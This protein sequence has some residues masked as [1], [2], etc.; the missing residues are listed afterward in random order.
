MPDPTQHAAHE[1]DTRLVH[2][3]ESFSDVVIGFSLA[4][5]A[6]TLAIPEHTHDLFQNPAWLLIYLWTFAVVAAIWFNHQRLFSVYFAPTR[7][8]IFLNFLL[9]SLVGL[10]VFFVQVFG[11]V[12]GA[13]DKGVAFYVYWIV[14]GTE[15]GILGALFALGT[16]S[17]WAVL[18][19]KQRQD[20]V[21]HAIRG[22]LLCAGTYFG[23]L[24]AGTLGEFR[25]GDSYLI[26]VPIL[27]AVG[28]SRLTLNRIR[29]TIV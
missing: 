5:L 2:R 16:R 24:L 6:L 21:H 4:L 19:V 10:V 15:F 28:L 29:K 1:T 26:T 13:A 12:H 25:F 9:L 23:I 8:A 11:K 27:A 3:I 7:I 20:G 17:R 18:D 22:A 14:L